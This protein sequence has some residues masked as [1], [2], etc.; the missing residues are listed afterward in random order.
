VDS[1]TKEVRLTHGVVYSQFGSKEAIVIES[2]RLA[3]AESRR[4]WLRQLKRRGR[5]P[6]LTTIAQGYLSARHRDEP[7]TGCLVAALGGEISR[8]ARDV[9]D[10][11]T[12]EFKEALKFSQN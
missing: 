10:A 12:A 8:Q 2:I 3:L 1:I 5:K 9:R 7:G 4:I 11:F 6:T